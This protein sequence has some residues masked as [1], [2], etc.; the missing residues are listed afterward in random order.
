MEAIKKIEPAP[1][2]DHHSTR[3]ENLLLDKHYQKNNSTISE[4]ESEHKIDSRIEAES[5]LENIFRIK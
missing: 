4:D 1:L 5:R 2:K 3:L